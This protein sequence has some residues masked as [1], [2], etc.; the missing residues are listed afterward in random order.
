LGRANAK[1]I[2]IR[3]GS[4]AQG[5]Q[6]KKASRQHHKKKN[7]KEKGGAI[8]RLKLNFPPRKMHRKKRECPYLRVRG[9][10][11]PP[12]EERFSKKK[13]MQTLS[14]DRTRLLREKDKQRD[15]AGK[16]LPVRILPDSQQSSKN[17]RKTSR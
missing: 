17:R 15:E 6:G 10:A 8:Y 2:R 4:A 12:G 9:E 5:K 13:S 1:N 16:G 14:G 11:V 7:K 3:I